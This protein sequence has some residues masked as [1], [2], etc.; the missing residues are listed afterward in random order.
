LNDKT[1][2]DYGIVQGSTIFMVVSVLG[3][4][5]SFNSLE[6]KINKQFSK[7]GPAYRAV[8]FGLNLHSK[9][10]NA[11]CEAYNKKIIIQKGFGKFNISK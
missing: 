6:K 10:N 9:C 8:I 1:I 5:F 2:K 3:G 4:L 11:S 7:I